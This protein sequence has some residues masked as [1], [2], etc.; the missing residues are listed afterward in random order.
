MVTTSTRSR[1]ELSLELRQLVMRFSAQNLRNIRARADAKIR[2]AQIHLEL[3]RERGSNSG[4]DFDRGVEESI[5]YHLFGARDAFL[6]E[7]GEYYSCSFAGADITP[8]KLRDA[9]QRQGRRSPELA[10][11][12]ALENDPASWLAHAKEMRDHSAHR[13]GVPRQFHMGG[14]NHGKVFPRNPLTGDLLE[15][16]MPDVLAAWLISMTDLL[17]RLRSSAIASNSA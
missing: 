14:V 12:W 3:L 13:H 15:Q 9:L 8:G 4:S 16:D 7:L 6:H 5:L 10:E 2:Y 17:E 11:L 1:L